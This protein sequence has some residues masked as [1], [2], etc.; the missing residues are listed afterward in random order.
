MFIGNAQNEIEELLQLKYHAFFTEFNPDSLKSKI[1]QENIELYRD[2]YRRLQIGLD[3]IEQFKYGLLETGKVFDGQE[4]KNIDKNQN[5]IEFEKRLKELSS[6]MKIFLGQNTEFGIAQIKCL[7]TYSNLKQS[8]EKQEYDEAL[9]FW[10]EMF[11]YFPS[12]QNAYS[13]GDILI[14]NI[15]VTFQK[16][17]ENADLKYKKS[18]EENNMASAD[19]YAEQQRYFLKQKELWVDTL[20]LM[21]DQRIKYFGNDKNFGK[22]WCLGKKGNYIMEYR[23]DSEFKQA[24]EFLKESIEIE[25][26]NSNYLIINDFFD[27]SML[28]VRSGN[29]TS[30]DLINNYL[31][32]IDILKKNSNKYKMLIDQERNKSTLDEKKIK[33][34]E[35]YITNN[36]L[37]ED[38]ISKY[39][40]SAEELQCDYLIASFNEHF[41]TDKSDKERLNNI[42]GILTYKECTNNS[43]YSQVVYALFQLE[44]SANTASKLA[45][46]HLKNENYN[47]AAQFF[48]KAYTLE[49]DINLKAEYYYY[50]ANVSFIQ[51]KYANARS[52]ALKAAELT[53]NFGKPYV[54]IAKLYAASAGSCG[55]DEFEKRAVYWTAVDKL[56]KA[57]SIDPSVEAEA[58]ELIKKYSSLF[59]NTEEGF[60][61]GI[62]QGNSYKVECWIQETTTVRY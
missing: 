44:A 49:N 38:K 2:Q 62:Y 13:K 30:E 20:L 55:N 60:M 50:A 39:F 10:R 16:E 32:S 1:N 48:E 9:E 42:I 17:S 45:L 21:Y 33:N 14:K 51:K 29:I 36:K 27:A 7:M 35:S 8:L 57:K 3:E 53:I 43:F 46:Y 26:E 31:L 54:L 58:D 11:V 47:E 59:P 56:I 34:W 41:D 18:I 24:Y 5:L 37:V 4:L 61:K 23:K 19:T 12:Y 22:G 25:K 52:L 6:Q 40:A 15:I 28:M